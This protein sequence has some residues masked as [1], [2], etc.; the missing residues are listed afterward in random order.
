MSSRH[1]LSTAHLPE[2][3]HAPRYFSGNS[4]L[5]QSCC[6]MVDGHDHHLRAGAIGPS[7]EMGKGQSI[8]PF[9]LNV[10]AKEPSRRVQPHSADIT[11]SDSMKLTVKLGR[12]A[13]NFLRRRRGIV[14]IVTNDIAAKNGGT[15]NSGVIEQITV[16]LLSTGTAEDT[17]DTT[18]DFAR[19]LRYQC[20]FARHW[21]RAMNQ[22]RHRKPSHC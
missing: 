19:A 17:T 5:M 11:R 22:F 14:T 3:L 6:G 12:V 15:I 9:H 4:G 7:V 2:L 8:G 10:I 20:I 13:L 1:P 18:L 21:T 16:K